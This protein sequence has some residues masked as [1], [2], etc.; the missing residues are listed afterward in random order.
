M[1]RLQESTI[2]RIAAST[3]RVAVRDGYADRNVRI[4]VL[5]GA[6]WIVS[7]AGIPHEAGFDHATRWLYEGEEDSP[8][9]KATNEW[10]TATVADVA[11]APKE[12]I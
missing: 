5:G 1:N 4:T 10:L 3:G 2:E 12:A 11:N 9:Q 7:D 6:R 8:E